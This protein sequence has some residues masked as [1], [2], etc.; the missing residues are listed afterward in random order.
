MD[1]KALLPGSG[2]Y[3]Q[4]PPQPETPLYR[5]FHP[6]KFL[7]NH[8]DNTFFHEIWLYHHHHALD[9]YP[10]L[11]ARLGPIC[12]EWVLWTERI[13]GTA[14]TVAAAWMRFGIRPDRSIATALRPQVPAPIKHDSEAV[15]GIDSKSRRQFGVGSKAHATGFIKEDG[16]RSNSVLERVQPDDPRGT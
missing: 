11:E 5:G 6:H 15:P 4:V 1:K 7:L 12:P 8:A 9:L 10:D 3:P 16:V 14:S 2:N 13:S